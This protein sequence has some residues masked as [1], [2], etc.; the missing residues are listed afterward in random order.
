MSNWFKTS[1][2]AAV[3]ALLLPLAACG[4]ADDNGGDVAM[5]ETART[6]SAGPETPRRLLFIHHSCGGQLM[7][8]P[9]ERAGGAPGSGRRCIYDSHPN[10]GGLRALLTAGGYDVSELSYESVLGADTDIRHWRRKFA[11]HM[12][13]IL[14]TDHQDRRYGDGTI[15]GI[16]AFKSCY[17][18][19]DF[20]GPGVEPGDPDAEE[21]TVA[22]AK[23]AYRALL[24][25]FR[26]R[27]D[28]LFVAFTAPPRAEPRR[29]LK[30]RLKG[31]FGSG[32]TPAD[33][34]RE[35]NTWLTDRENGWL[36]AY[37]LPNVVVFDYYDILTG[38]R[39]NWSA[40]PTGG[41]QDSHP[42]RQG[43]AKA[44]AAFVP[45][46]NAAVAGMN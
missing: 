42:S 4:T 28:V 31:A 20:T 37:A 30:D 41:G 8:D 45:F 38:G 24:P 35:F 34:A 19:N 15:N 40:Y 27:P 26:A 43:N 22:N 9:G 10:G 11:E 21:L 6:S 44:A 23:A 16:V 7:A 3:L 5:Q 36:S 17:P 12:D 32:P 2:T 18:N 46:I 33:H 25:H 14:A 1:G 29:D 39:G 13:A